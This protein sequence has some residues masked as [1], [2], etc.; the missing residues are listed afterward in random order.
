MIDDKL[1]EFRQRFVDDNDIPISVL[2]SPCFET[3]LDI[4]ESNFQSR[5]KYD[6]LTKVILPDWYNNSIQGYLNDYEANL[7][8]IINAFKQSDD[9]TD[10]IKCDID[11]LKVK[12]PVGY[13]EI[14]NLKQANPSNNYFI[15]IN[16]VDPEFQ[17]LKAFNPYIVHDFKTFG[18]LLN[19][20]LVGF[21]P[22][23]YSKLKYFHKKVF[24]ALD[25]QRIRILDERIIN[26]IYTFIKEYFPK[27]GKPFS[28]DAN[29]IT[30]KL[31]K[32]E[33][34]ENDSFCIEHLEKTF[35]KELGLNTRID[36]F[37]LFATS[38]CFEDDSS[39][40][41][42][43]F[44]KSNYAFKSADEYS[45]IPKDYAPQIY[46]MLNGI[47]TIGKYDLFS[48]HNN[49]LEKNLKVLRLNQKEEKAA[50][51]FRYA[52]LPF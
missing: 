15:T 21:K 24:E 18:D 32:E 9:Y 50:N 36:R 39:K 38:F 31:S 35:K 45:G 51:S 22:K 12:L 42:Y 30:Y 2:E 19:D 48:Y 20:Y 41:L 6:I 49:K 47:Q 17:A 33:F 52:D 26:V 28:I 14:Y 29:S 10:F 34:L 16:I 27:W 46:K 7:L 43:I 8:K 13:N 1:K 3:R 5:S 4:F 23:Y 25:T 11:K 40:L 44:K 37:R